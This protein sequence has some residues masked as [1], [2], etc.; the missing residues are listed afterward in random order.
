MAVDANI[1]I[2]ERVKEELRAGKTIAAAIRAGE[3]RAWP[4]I[5][6]SNISTL[7]SCGVLYFFGLQSGGTIIMGF[8]LVLAIGVVVSP[9]SAVV[10]TRALLEVLLSRKWAHNPRFFGLHFLTPP[11][12]GATRRPSLAAGTRN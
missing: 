5:R 6:D 10:V 9:F 12:P 1:L 3:E 2:F 4:S 7:I 8:G 11:R